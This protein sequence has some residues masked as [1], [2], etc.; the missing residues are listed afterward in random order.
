MWCSVVVT[1]VNTNH[2]MLTSMNHALTTTIPLNWCCFGVVN[3]LATKRCANN[4]TNDT[5]CDDF[6]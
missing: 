1:I 6:H 4:T 5:E 2:A 3:H